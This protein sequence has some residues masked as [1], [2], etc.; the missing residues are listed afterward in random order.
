MQ[1]GGRRRVSAIVWCLRVAGVTR[2]L[3]GVCESETGTR[4]HERISGAVEE[5]C[6]DLPF[7]GT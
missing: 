2:A 6:Q 4:Q 5:V 7:I 1:A 3:P